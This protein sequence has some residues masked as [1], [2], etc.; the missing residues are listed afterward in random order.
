MIEAGE[1]VTKAEVA[2]LKAEYEAA[3]RGRTLAEQDAEAAEQKAATLETEANEKVSAEV[4]KAAAKIKADYEAEVKRLKDQ[5]AELRKPKPVTTIDNDTGNVVSSHR[6]LTESE[7]EV[8][9]AENDDM[10]GADF[11][12]SASDAERATAFFGS[13]RSMVAAN[14]KPAAVYAYITNRNSKD[15]VAEYMG[16]VTTVLSQLQAVKDMDNG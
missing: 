16:M 11:N 12:E 5:I 3:K 8:I 9:D 10:A 6:P 15:L 7:A 14:A 13:V 2:K 4:S 1:V